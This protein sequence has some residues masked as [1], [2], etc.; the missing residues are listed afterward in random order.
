MN[1]AMETQLAVY[2]LLLA[3]LSYLVHHLAPK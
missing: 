1:K 2:S 3:G